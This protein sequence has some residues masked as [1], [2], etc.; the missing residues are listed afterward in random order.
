MWLSRKLTWRQQAL[1]W[2][3][4]SA[5][6]KALF[7]REATIQYDFHGF[8]CTFPCFKV[9]VFERFPQYHANLGRVVAATTAKYPG[10]RMVDIGANTGDSAIIMAAAAPSSPILSVEASPGYAELCRKNLSTIRNVTV[11]NSFV[12]T[13]TGTVSAHYIE[14]DGTGH[15]ALEEGFSTQAVSLSDLLKTHHH[16]EEAKFVK[17][18]TDGFDGRI[19]KGALPWL[20]SSLPTL[21]WEC[22]LSA[23]LAVGGPGRAIFDLLAGAGYEY[24]FVFYSNAGDQIATAHASDGDL[25]DDLSWYLGERVTRDRMPPNYCDVCAIPRQ[26][27]EVYLALRALEKRA[28]SERDGTHRSRVLKS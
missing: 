12:D 26:D 14:E 19:I 13:A 18:D 9:L 2:A 1:L 23:D 3:G 27:S 11:V 5:L 8:P 17:I 15:A 20:T 10:S 22:D 24:F 16:S 21:F 4:W 28:H 25:I 7:L 6:T